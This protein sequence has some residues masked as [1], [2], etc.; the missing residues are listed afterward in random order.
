M[1]L[2]FEDGVARFDEDGVHAIPRALRTSTQVHRFVLGEDGTTVTDKFSGKTDAQI[3]ALEL[4]EASANSLAENKA[5]I[6]ASIK[7]EAGERIK[8]SDWKVERATERADGSL[9]AVL[10]D[11]ETIRTDSNTAEA[12]VSAMTSVDDVRAFSW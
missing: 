10:A 9:A 11:R 7:R 1:K 5:R 6:I 12:A 3:I 4:T 2:T 8:P